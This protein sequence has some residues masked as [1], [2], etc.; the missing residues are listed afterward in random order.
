MR[1]LPLFLILA[2]L[3]GCTRHLGAPDTPTAAPTAHSEAVTVIRDRVYTPAD[4]PQALHA[5]LYHAGPRA[6]TRRCWWC[7][8]AAG[9]AVRRRIWPI[10]PGIWPNRASW[11]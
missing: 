4:W 8:A 9:H 1:L 6:A 5:N 2:A 3:G 10:W 11:R 7:T